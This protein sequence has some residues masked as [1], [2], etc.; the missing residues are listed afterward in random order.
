MP[1]VGDAQGSGNFALRNAE[2]IAEKAGFG[3]PSINI[4]EDI[5]E[6]ESSIEDVQ[7]ND[8]HG[9]SK[10]D[11][12]RN[13][14]T[15]TK[16]GIIVPYI[17][18]SLPSWFDI[19]CLSAASSSNLYDW[20]I[21]VTDAPLRHT[22]P[23]VKLVQMDKR[24]IYRR[25]AS[26]DPTIS[27]RDSDD[28][29]KNADEVSVS[30][31]RKLLT[32][33]PYMMVELKPVFGFLFKDL[34]QTYSHWAY[35][36]VDQMVGRLHN[37][38]SA[39]ELKQYDIV[40][41]SFGDNYRMYIRGQLSIHRNDPF[42]NN[43]WRSCTHLSRYGDRLKQYYMSD[44]KK[45]RFFSAEGCYSRVVADH[46][47]VSLLVSASQISDAMNVGI[48]DK[49]S[50][51]LG[52]SLFRC[53]KGPLLAMGRERVADFYHAVSS[54]SLNK[55]QEYLL[56]SADQIPNSGVKR[57]ALHQEDYMCAYWLPPEYQVCLSKVPASADISSIAGNIS[58]VPLDLHA[59]TSTCREGSTSHFQSWKKNYYHFM[60]RAPP[61]DSRAF[62][63][64]EGGFIP[65]RL[66]V[67]SPGSS[68]RG[69]AVGIAQLPTFGEL[70]G[71]DAVDGRLHA[72][73]ISVGKAAQA[74]SQQGGW[75]HRAFSLPRLLNVGLGS[76]GNE[77]TLALA[78]KQGSVADEKAPATQYCAGF[79]PD[80]KRC[81]CHVLGSHIKVAQVAAD[82]DASKERIPSGIY[83]SPVQA[84]GVT[85]ISVGW[86]SE[87]Y[88]GSF[89]EMLDAWAGP[90]LLVLGYHGILDEKNAPRTD[91]T[92]ILVDLTA[93][94]QNAHANKILTLPDATLL[95]IGLDAAGTDLVAVFPKGIVPQQPMDAKQGNPAAAP[96]R[97]QL[98]LAQRVQ[99]MS[100]VMLPVALILPTFVFGGKQRGEQEIRRRLKE[101]GHNRDASLRSNLLREIEDT[102]TAYP[103]Q[104]GHGHIDEGQCGFAQSQKLKTDY[105]KSS[106]EIIKHG[107]ALGEEAAGRIFRDM[108]FNA[109]DFSAPHTLSLPFV[110]NQTAGAHGGG[111]VRFP[112]ELSGPGCFG[113]IILRVL[114]GSGFH[115]R[116]AGAQAFAS[117]QATAGT[118]PS[119][120][121][122][123]SAASNICA[124]AHGDYSHAEAMLQFATMLNKFYHRAV[125]LRATGIGELYSNMVFGEYQ[126]EEQQKLIQKS[127][128][129]SS[130]DMK[131]GSDA[132]SKKSKNKRKDKRE[133][134]R[135]WD[136]KS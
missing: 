25:I 98:M 23:N 1:S 131:K 35:A 133:R 111:F 49:E 113:S 132:A 32:L 91:V 123:Y 29:A 53:H 82:D 42:I 117:S 90:K 28:D 69:S 13:E 80:L 124:C 83:G 103:N 37:L 116:W 66:L 104:S 38:V 64:S 24:E 76:H 3:L 85:M 73:D 87:F 39:R 33:Q 119:G 112:E 72:T 57:V 20:I 17:G 114:A 11:S 118:K 36:D 102:L 108:E 48:A 44:F 70:R 27:S 99:D 34:L 95:N 52:S 129:V 55:L 61:L 9:D 51:F 106:Y 127:Q 86:E 14:N 40:T 93:C 4:S 88:D 84:E 43:L 110:F 56:R 92:V 63:V 18:D 41:T 135:A 100:K 8:F 45:W 78:S 109:K 60:V 74:K 120:L 31:V 30:L 46:P 22:P 6:S 125:E 81:V 7:H 101:E 12:F 107:N 122:D 97:K 75:K 50:F 136:A 26:M 21:L 105:F 121:S 79:S 19:F 134:E 130:E 2:K 115:L 47:D 16:V 126:E 96:I 15:V 59:A 94:L 128:A 10:H 89:N 5:N 62:V 65:L 58:Y 71:G 67:A 77:A 68:L 54:S